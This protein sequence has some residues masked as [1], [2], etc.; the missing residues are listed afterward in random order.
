M[1]K[2][3][4]ILLLVIAVSSCTYPDKSGEITQYHLDAGECQYKGH[5][6]IFFY[7]GARFTTSRVLSVVHNPDCK[8][9]EKD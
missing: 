8:C 9:H 1:K 3:L 5:S 7:D 6:Y 4:L 2:L